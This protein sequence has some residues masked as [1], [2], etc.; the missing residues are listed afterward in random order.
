MEPEGF[1]GW[2]EVEYPRVFAS[3]LLIAGDVGEAQDVTNEAFTRAF[4][5]WDRIG[6]MDAPGGWAHRVALNV[7][8]RRARRR[9]LE[10]RLLLRRTPRADA[11]APAG[12]AWSLVQSLPERQR[13][14]V[15]LRYGEDL[16][17]AAVAQIMGV[18][19]GTVASTLA[20]ARKALAKDL[21]ESLE[22][23]RRG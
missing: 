20:A 19:R 17:E 6:R 22:E 18:R 16:P 13:I 8:R 7:L 15:V 23:S 11:P 12:E 14:A 21:A 1:D 4:A 3:M 10:D 9:Q 5:G 2:Y